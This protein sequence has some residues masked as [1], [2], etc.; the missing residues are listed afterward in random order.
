[1]SKEKTEIIEAENSELMIQ[2]AESHLPAQLNLNDLG[3]MVSEVQTMNLEKATASAVNLRT[4]YLKFEDGSEG[5]EIRRVFLGLSKEMSVD[6][7]THEEKGLVDCALFYDP[8][9]G[10]LQTAMQTVLV[11]VFVDRNIEPKTPVAITFVGKEQSKRGLW[12][13]NFDVRLL[14][15]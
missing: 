12:F 10:N 9:T 15:V 7:I 13:Q 2:N 5:E 1:M 14:S 4:S 11:G 8:K 6:P 3:G